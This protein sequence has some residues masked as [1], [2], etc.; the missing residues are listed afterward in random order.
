MRHAS[1]AHPGWPS[2]RSLPWPASFHLRTSRGDS[3]HLVRRSERSFRQAGVTCPASLQLDAAAALP[4]QAPALRRRALDCCDQL[5][6]AATESVL[7]REVARTAPRPVDGCRDVDGVRLVPVGSSSRGAGSKTI[8][9]GPGSVQYSP[10]PSL[11]LPC[12]SSFLVRAFSG[13]RKRAA[14]RAAW[15]RSR[16]RRR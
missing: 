8:S 13:S 12:L 10:H 4:S 3:H 16:E 11:H 2:S 5:R 15:R 9:P 7:P 6:P 14:L 1:S